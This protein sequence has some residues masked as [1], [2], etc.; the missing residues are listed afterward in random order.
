[1][2]STMCQCRLNYIIQP[3]KALIDVNVEEFVRGNDRDN[4]SIYN[5]SIYI[6]SG[7]EHCLSQFDHFKNKILFSCTE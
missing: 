4:I 1:M 7:N 6:I 5:I 3:T 2:Q